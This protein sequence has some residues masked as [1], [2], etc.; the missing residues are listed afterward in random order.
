[1]A[2]VAVA[3]SVDL[4]AEPHEHLVFVMLIFTEFIFENTNLKNKEQ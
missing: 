3:V 1:M 2:T 4:V